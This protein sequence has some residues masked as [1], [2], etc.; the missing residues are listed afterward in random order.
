V[1]LRSLMLT[2]HSASPPGL[3]AGTTLLGC[4]P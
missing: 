3:V 2:L 4:S 1:A